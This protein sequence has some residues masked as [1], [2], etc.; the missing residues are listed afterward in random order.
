MKPSEEAEIE[1]KPYMDKFNKLN[2]D[3]MT[4]ELIKLALINAHVDGQLCQLNK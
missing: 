2:L 4:R 1:T 3:E